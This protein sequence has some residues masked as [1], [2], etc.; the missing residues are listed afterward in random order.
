M[1][2]GIRV[3]T[4]PQHRIRKEEVC[5]FIIFGKYTNSI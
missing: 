2:I 3:W 1:Q 5:E 4:K